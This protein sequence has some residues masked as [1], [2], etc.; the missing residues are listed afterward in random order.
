MIVEIEDAVSMKKKVSAV[1]GS[2]GC[3]DVAWSFDDASAPIRTQIC[4]YSYHMQTC[5]KDCSLS[6]S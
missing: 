2:E 4:S 5:R 3:H 6:F 1:D